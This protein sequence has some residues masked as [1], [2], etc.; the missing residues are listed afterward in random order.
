MNPWDEVIEPEWRILFD[1]PVPRKKVRVMRTE[2]L[3]RRRQSRRWIGE[4]GMQM[5]ERRTAWRPTATR[6][7]MMDYAAFIGLSI[8]II[9]C[10]LL[11]LSSVGT[12]GE[13]TEADLLVWS[14]I[15]AAGLVLG[16]PILVYRIRSISRLFERAIEV[17]GRVSKVWF[18]KDRGRVEYTYS[19]RG[20]EF[21]SGKAVMKNRRTS[22]LQSGAGVV[23]IVDPDD[24]KKSLIRD[25]YA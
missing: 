10:A 19:F 25:L 22:D 17:P 11:A 5:G 14:I 4:I 15:A 12:F 24:P 18:V 16:L 8:A 23:V 6:I 9:P 20:Q 1:L 2:S 13:Q 7:L 3:Y 21:S